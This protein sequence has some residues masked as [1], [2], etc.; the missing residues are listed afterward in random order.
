MRKALIA[1]ATLMIG[2]ALPAAASADHY[3]GNC[4]SNNGDKVAGALVGGI[5]GGLIGSEIAEKGDGTEGT[6]IG[7]AIG[8]IAGAAIADSDNCRPRTA[9]NQRYDRRYDQRYNQRYDR[10]YDQRYD[11][12]YNQRYDRRYDRRARGNNYG[13]YNQNTYNDR[14]FNRGTYP[15]ATGYRSEDRARQRYNERQ[16]NS[17]NG[18]YQRNVNRNYTGSGQAY[19]TGYSPTNFVYLAGQTRPNACRNVNR[20]VRDSRGYYSQ[21][22]TQECRCYDGQYRTWNG[23]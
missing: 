7:A 9:Y 15:N 18:Y 5:L 12:R 22:Q 10:R 4:R 23:Y 14:S 6:I 2:L 13:Y 17:N 19:N 3:R 16:W 8:G 20:R 11:R 1:T 21:V